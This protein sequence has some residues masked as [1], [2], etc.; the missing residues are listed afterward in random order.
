MWDFPKLK[1]G[2][3]VK[4]QVETVAPLSK[5]N[6]HGD[7]RPPAWSERVGKAKSPLF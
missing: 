4:L 3:K 5:A 7:G 2:F 6:A 1:A